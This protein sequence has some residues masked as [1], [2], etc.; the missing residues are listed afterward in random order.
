M[1]LPGSQPFFSSRGVHRPKKISAVGMS[2]RNIEMMQV[3]SIT[4]S[5][6]IFDLLPNMG[7]T[8]RERRLPRPTFAKIWPMIIA[9]S[10]KK[11]PVPEKPARISSSA[12]NPTHAPKKRT[13][14]AVTAIGTASVSHRNT[15]T[16]RTKN[17]SQPAWSSPCGTKLCRTAKAPK[18]RSK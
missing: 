17:P 8:Y 5:R 14:I 9:P 1:D 2:A 18:I 7:R 12:A 6:T 3:P 4:L 16:K 13:K 11:V 10:R 15:A